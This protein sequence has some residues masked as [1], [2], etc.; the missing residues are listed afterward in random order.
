M[1][2]TETLGGLARDPA[3]LDGRPDVAVEVRT[4]KSGRVFQ[5]ALI[6]DAKKTRQ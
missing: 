6:F 3:S 1:E 5:V 4:E 2:A